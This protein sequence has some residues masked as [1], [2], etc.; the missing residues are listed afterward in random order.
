MSAFQFT[1]ENSEMDFGSHGAYGDWLLTIS[2]DDGGFSFKLVD[3]ETCRKGVSK[4]WFAVIQ[5]WVDDDT[6]PKA[7]RSGRKSLIRQAYTDALIERDDTRSEDRGC[8]EYHQMRG[9]A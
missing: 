9:A 8:F 1:Y 4:A 2:T 5:E 3:V 6:A 7:R